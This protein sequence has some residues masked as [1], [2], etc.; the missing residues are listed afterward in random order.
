M[1]KAMQEQQEIIE[2]QQGQ[3]KT[4]EERLSRLEALMA[5]K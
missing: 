3:I 4:L 1:V 5:G 2:R